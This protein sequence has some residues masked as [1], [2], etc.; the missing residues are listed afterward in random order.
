MDLNTSDLSNLDSSSPSV[1]PQ[2]Y[3]CLLSTSDLE[4]ADGESETYVDRI[5]TSEL[6]EDDS[7]INVS[8][9]TSTP[10]RQ[11]SN[12]SEHFS[13][14]EATPINSTTES[15]LGCWP[16]EDSSNDEELF[17]SRYIDYI[18]SP[19]RFIHS[20]YKLIYYPFANTIDCK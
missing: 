14:R 12:L 8:P 7:S 5:G 15:D 20:T 11:W 13:F 18:I 16:M 6:S 10:I 19:L 3:Q 2:K 17:Q 1:T 9:Q 4:Q